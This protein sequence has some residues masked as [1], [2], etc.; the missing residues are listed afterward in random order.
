MVH[1]EIIIRIFQTI[2]NR[3]WNAFFEYFD[4][5]ATY[6][7]PGYVPLS[8]LGE[9]LAFYRQDR[10]IKQG[11]HRIEK[12]LSDDEAACCWGV[13]DGTSKN[14]ERLHEPFADVYRIAKGKIVYRKT[15]FY[16]AA[17]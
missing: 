4:T 10:I 14:D 17:I 9:I 15:F 1:E 8:G 7:R 13:F 6:E 5:N 2:D 11:T 16:R 12:I 3:R